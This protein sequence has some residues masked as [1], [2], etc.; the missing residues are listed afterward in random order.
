MTDLELTWKLLK[1]AVLL[2]YDEASSTE[3]MKS[4]AS[5]PPLALLLKV[6]AC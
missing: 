1:S 6:H 4:Y 5:K 3:E 2:K